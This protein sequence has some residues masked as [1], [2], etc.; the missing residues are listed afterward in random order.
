MKKLVVVA[1]LAMMSAVGAT[2]QKCNTMTTINVPKTPPTEPFPGCNG[3]D[4]TLGGNYTVALTQ[5]MDCAGDMHTRSVITS[6]NVTASSTLGFTYTVR[7]ATKQVD[8]VSDG[9]AAEVTIIHQLK[10]MGQGSLNNQM[11]LDEMHVTNSAGLGIGSSTF[12]EVASC[13]GN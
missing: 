10:L 4:V 11:L 1:I 8:N 13:S 12:H 2:A 6:A 5:W 9:S 7:F 3:D